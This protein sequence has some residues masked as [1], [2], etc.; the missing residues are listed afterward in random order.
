MNTT[1]VT[2]GAGTAYPSEAPVFTSVFSGVRVTR[3]L[4]LYICFVDRF[5]YIF[6]CSLCC[7]IFFDMRILIAPSV[8]T[9]SSLSMAL[10]QCPFGYCSRYGGISQT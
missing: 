5:M 8:S 1:G 6:F 9:N 7:L 2:S 3:S 4:V 10:V